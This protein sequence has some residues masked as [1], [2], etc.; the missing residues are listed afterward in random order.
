MYSV[1]V[2]NIANSGSRQA[3]DQ[4]ESV[5]VIPPRPSPQLILERCTENTCKRVSMHEAN[6]RDSLTKQWVKS[7]LESVKNGHRHS[8]T[9]LNKFSVHSCL[10]QNL[11]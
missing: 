9:C 6:W 10:D 2:E 11:L 4:D 3:E 5:P 8:D 1:S 7:R